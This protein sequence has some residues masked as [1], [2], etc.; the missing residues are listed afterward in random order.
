MKGRKY[1]LFSL[2]LAGSM[3]LAGCQGARTGQGGDV[4][5]VGPEESQ[6]NV[7]TL[8]VWAEAANFDMLSQMIEE[9]EA[10][11]AGEAQ[12]DIRLE[13]KADS[14]A[15]DNVL[16]DVHNAADVF[17]FADDQLSSLVAAGAIA[18]VP[19]AE[20]VSQA[21]LE[22]A[23]EAASINGTLYAYPMTADNGY[24]LYYDKRYLSEK[25]VETMDSLL[26]AAEEAGKKISM[27]C[28][29]GWY[30]YAFFGNTGME[31]GINEDGVTNYC[32]WNTTEGDI[33]GVDVAEAILKI[34]SS[35][36]FENNPDSDFVSRAAS[37]E[38][39]A[40]ISGI[41]NVVELKEAWGGDYGAVKLPTYTCGGKQIQMSSFT[42]YKMMGVNAYSQHVEWAHALA[43]WLT[44]E[45]NQTT[46]FKVR[47][48]GPS[49]K[50]AA[51]SDEVRQVPAIQA[52]ISQGAYGQLQRV[53][54]NFWTPFQKFGEIMAA[55]NPDNVD[56]QELMDELVNGIT[57]STV[58]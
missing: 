6:D 4:P 44:N 12:F 51:A 24:F 27:E 17:P 8:T 34:T 14:G 35:P 45:Q 40:G 11:H 50:N 22:E 25:D 38:V 26:A 3:L 53:G 49:N 32:N 10:A 52:V 13:E 48:Q 56:M 54:N 42:G 55:G 15:R 36:A 2:L 28:T 30:M 47:N 21:N 41:W 31:F 57:A 23:V 1:K 29:S 7:V 9:F 18:A 33:T 39:I 5:A 43:E 58:N 19:N 46:R 37:G 20:A 16:G